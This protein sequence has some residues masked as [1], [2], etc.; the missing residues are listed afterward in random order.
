[1]P[2]ALGVSPGTGIGVGKEEEKA[3]EER[4]RHG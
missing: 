4:T 2:E 3:V 1:M